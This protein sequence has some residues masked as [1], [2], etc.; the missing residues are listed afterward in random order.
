MY[1]HSHHAGGSGFGAAIW[2]ASPLSIAVF[3]L[4]SIRWLYQFQTGNARTE[5]FCP[6]PEYPFLFSVYLFSGNSKNSPELCD[7]AEARLF[8]FISPTLLNATQWPWTSSFDSSEF[9]H[10]WVRAIHKQRWWGTVG[11][12]EQKVSLLVLSTP[13]S[14]K[15]ILCSVDL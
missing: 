11:E 12:S 7:C 3:M 8:Y 9:V 6:L 15:F 4:L 10:I 2:R 13:N 1:S 14:F 5:Q